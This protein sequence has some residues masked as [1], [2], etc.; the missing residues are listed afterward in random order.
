MLYIDNNGTAVG[1]AARVILHELVHALTTPILEDN[2]NETDYRGDTVTRSNEIYR[3]LGI[4][5]QNSYI[6]QSDTGQG[7][8]ADKI[9]TLG[10]NYTNGAAID[11]SVVVDLGINVDSTSWDSTDAGN[12]NDLLIGGLWDNKLTAGDGNDFL[13]GNEGNDTLYGGKGDDYL[14]GGEGADRLEGGEGYDTYI[15]DKQDTIMDEDGKGCVILDGTKLGLATRKKGETEYRDGYGNVFLYTEPSDGNPGH[16]SVNGGLQIENYTNGDLEIVL[17]E[18]P[19]DPMEPIRDKTRV[20]SKYASPIIL[21]LDGDGVETR[22]LANGTHFDHA[23]DGFAELTGWVGQDDGLLVRDL[24]G[25]GLIDSGRELFGSETLLANG[26]K[27]ANGFE[28]LKELDSNGD[29]IIDANDTAFA[30]LR[31]W[32]DSNGNGR[33]DEGE[34]LTLEQ[35]GVQSINLAYTNSNTVDAQGN[36]HKQTG[37][38]T[39]T[40]GQIRKA[41]DVWFAVDPMYSIATEQV[42]VPDDIAALPTARGYG[43]VRDLRQAMAM[44]ATGQLKV[45][46]TAFTQA[47]SAQDRMALVRQIIYRWTGVQDINPASR[48]NP[49][50]GNA[51]GD[52]RKLEALEKFLGEAWLQIGWGANPGRDA[53][54][55]LDEAYNLLEALVYSQLMMQ[56][57]LKGLFEQIVYSWDAETQSAQ[58]DLSQV[59]HTLASQIEA[60]RE[61]GLE[62]LGDFLLSLRGMGRLD[63]VDLDAFKAALLPLGADVAQTFDSA[64]TGWLSSNTPSDGNNRLIGTELDDIIDGKGG[65][66]LIFGRGGNDTLIG[67]M[68]NDV[69][70]G[71]AGNDSLNGGYGS[72]TYRFG[73]GDGHD[74]ISEYGSQSE[75]DR[76]ELKAGVTP[77]DVRLE[78]GSGNDLKLTIRDTGETITVKNHFTSTAY[79][80]EEIIFADGTVWDVEAIKSRV[81]LGEDG[82]DQLRGFDKRDDLI[83]GGAGN[84]VLMGYSGNDMLLGGEGNDTLDGGDGDDTLDGGAGDDVLKGGTGSDTYLFGRGD[85]HDTINEYS[86]VPG[87]TDRIQLK[88]GITP[89]DVRLERVRILSNGWLLSDDL[90]LTIRDTGETITVKNHFNNSYG[91]P[92]YAIE[93][94]VFAN[95]TV[96]DTEAIKSQTLIGGD[97]DDT[98][99]GF[100]NRDDLLIG[101]AGNDVLVGGSGN[102]TLVGGAGNDTLE[103][104]AGSDTYRFGLGDGQDEI[105]EGGTDG[106]DVLE[107]GPGITPDDVTVR[108]TLNGGM[109]ITLQDGSR[110]IV[111][112]QTW[113]SGWGIEQLRFANGTVWNR[114]DLAERAIA[115]TDGDDTIVGGYGNNTLDGGPGNDVFYDLG[116]YDT[117]LFG[118]GDGQD[119]I[120]DRDGRIQFKTGIDQNDIDFTYD[121]TDL[122]ATIAA[123]GDAI[124]IKDWLGSWWRI[125]RFDFANGASLS[126]ND[127]LAKLNVGEGSEILYGSPG[128]DTLIGTEKNSTIYGREGSDLLDGGAGSDVLYGEAGNDTLIGGAGNDTLYGG[129]GDDVLMG[130]DGDDWLFGGAGDD[131]LDGGAGRDWLYG[132]EGKNIYRMTPGMDLDMA[133]GESIQVAEDTVV[134]AAGIGP[135]DI[136]VQLGDLSWSEAPGDVGYR[137]L[138]IG[139]GGNDALVIQNANSWQNPDL[140]QGAIQHFRFAD[141]TEWTLADLIARADGGKL[142]YQWRESGDPTTLIGSAG[143]DTIR[144]DTGESVIVRAG[145]NN[146][147]IYLAAGNN[148]VSAG[149]GDDSINTGPGND[150]I[151]GETGDDWIDAG[152]GDDVILFNYGDGNDTLTA[153]KGMDTLSFGVTITSDMLSLAFNEYGVVVLTID[154]GAGGSITLSDAT[155]D[156]LRGDLERLQF[157]DADGK[158]RLFDFTGWLEANR[159]TLLGSTAPLAFD[160]AG[161][162]LTG[163]VA[164]VGGLEAVAYAQT[165]DLFGTAHLAN[166]TPTDGDDVIYGTPEGDLIDAGAGND[167][168]LGLAG[169]DT[170][171]GGEG[172]DILDGGDGDDILDGGA[173]NDTIYGGYGADTLIGGTG[174]DELYGGWGGDT[175]VY[176]PGDG[177]TIIDD[178]HHVLNWGRSVV[179]TMMAAFEYGGEI[180]YGGMI[181]DDDPNILSFGPGIRP[182][183]LRYSEHNGDLVITFANQPGD[184]VILRGYEPGRATQTRSVDIIRFADGTE[185]VAGSIDIRGKSEIANY[186]NAWLY[187]TQFADTLIGGD[188]DDTFYGNGGADRLAGGAGS[189]TYVIYK[190]WDSPVAETQIAEIWRPQDTNRIELTG[191]VNADDLRLAFDGRDLL[192]RYTPEGDTVRFLGFDPRDPNMPAPVQEISLP[193]EGITLSFDDLLARGVDYGDNPGTG[194]PQGPRIINRGDGEILI[195]EVA[196]EFSDILR[197]GPGIDAEAIRKNLRFESDGK[198]GHVLRIAYGDEGDVLCLAGFDPDDAL[199]S[200]LIEYYE[201]ADGP[202]LDYEA[203]L[204]EGFVVEGDGQDNELTGTN[205]ADRLYGHD[206][207]DVL[208]GKGGYNEFYGGKGNDTLIGGDQVDGYFF[209]RGD[210]ID[211][212]IDGPSD[213]FI[214]FGP[215]IG[216]SDLTVSWEDDT[217]VLRYGPGDE[218]RI[219]DFIAKT[220]DGTPPVT[221]I[222]FDDGD[223]VSIPS[224]I[225][226]S[227]TVQ[228]NAGEL[229]AATQDAMYWYTI[230]LADFDQSGPFGKARLLNLRQ[231]DGSALPGWL[232]FDAERGMLLGTPTNDDVGQL[233]LRVEIWGDYGLLATQQVSLLVNNVNDAPEIGTLLVDQQAKQDTSFTYTLPAGSFYDVDVGDVLTYTATLDNGDPLPDWL[234][235]DA[236]TQTFTGTPANGDVGKLQLRVT[237]TDL[238]G[239]SASQS[240]TLDVMSDGDP[241]LPITAPDTASVLEDSVVIGN[242][243]AN[244]TNPGTVASFRIDG[245]P[246]VYTAG[247]TATIAEG[248]LTI[249]SHGDYTFMPAQDYSGLVPQ[250]TYTTSS[251]LSSTLDITVIPVADAPVVTVTLGELETPTGNITTIDWTNA[252]TTSNGF[253]MQAFTNLR[254]DLDQS[255]AAEG[256]FVFDRS[257]LVSSGVGVESGTIKGFGSSDNSSL[258]QN[259]SGPGANEISQSGTKV[260]PEDWRSE[261]VRVTF[262]QSVVS[263]TVQFAWLAILEHAQY[264]A[265][266]ENGDVVVSGIVNGESDASTALREINIAGNS[267]IKSI[268]FFAPGPYAGGANT[269][270]FLIY[271]IQ[272][273]SPST[274]PS[275]LPVAISVVPTD[276]DGSE[277]VTQITVA[278]TGGVLSAGTDNHDGTWT[279]RADDPSPDYIWSV[280]THGAV[281]IKDLN[282]NDLGITVA[283]NHAGSVMVDV[284]ATV[285]DSLT[286]GTD[287]WTDST[288]GSGSAMLMIGQ[289]FSL[290]S[291]GDDGLGANTQT[292]S[293][294]LPANLTSTTQVAATVSD[295]QSESISDIFTIS[296]NNGSNAA[297]QQGNEGIGAPPRHTPNQNDRP[298]T[299]LGQPGNQSKNGKAERSVDESLESFLHGFGADSPSLSYVSR[300]SLDSGELAHWGEGQPASAETSD[301]ARRWAALSEVLNRLDAERQAAPGWSDVHWGAGPTGLAGLLQGGQMAGAGVDAISLAS[302]GS[303][304][305]SLAGLHEGMEKI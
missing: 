31:V 305:K 3:D 226:D 162:E 97:G 169:N 248:T 14:N 268:E 84:D 254:L 163:T 20:A 239:A 17:V 51:I 128:D 190:E 117:Y 299:V 123:S 240:F 256:K 96:W 287:T 4:P 200:H 115:G 288:T 1:G 179:P 80:I 134:F 38:Y 71:G 13:Y 64:L 133:Y 99:L 247:Q 60:D 197:F 230:P 201:F 92:Y 273:A 172:N 22:S 106:E 10:F 11:R 98:L 100:D 272:F 8:K 103:G 210:G 165:G 130:G 221:A 105:I 193:W 52:A 205:L 170:I 39:T 94:I 275:T 127:V 231:A 209:E 144:D 7:P 88:A 263:A 16:L 175:Y 19:D 149:S 213:N 49:S 194:E 35:A 251:G 40:D 156:N 298:D 50:W 33:V 148:I 86:W 23:A 217:L 274:E 189:D 233:E 253:T 58:G 199:G 147:A 138:V 137:D 124:R 212:I 79:G 281:T 259:S 63:D 125:D 223:M 178:D 297:K 89:D 181:V 75:T 188:G 27:A 164:P 225:S 277:S 244:D 136:T 302:S 142:G 2:W 216:K 95:G 215:G 37:S 219:P 112:N 289:S 132:G 290:G 5:E 184:R 44:D 243:L 206:G 202:V 294:T 47:D 76:L 85:G 236:V 143:D 177:Q 185:I 261:L 252:K 65:N 282:G 166:N 183:D 155:A 48:T 70:D 167:I 186:E 284:S 122:I 292:F 264:V 159:L 90:K 161:F 41:E 158:A 295:G 171:F 57:H 296:L 304:F 146:D 250:V 153:G 69:L 53:A 66:D 196:G 203:L 214:V 18:E 204:S 9:L 271:S 224:L 81:L 232:M 291:T 82:D 74:M 262:D 227:E 15:A 266:A 131:D 245:D 237:A 30:E 174:N 108:W 24:N 195:N 242:V 269:D 59:A 228:W 25:N 246:A 54:R 129:D 28:A 62:V 255:N 45:L 160:G 73:R 111:R 29:G 26:K 91:T 135:E 241:Q 32:K 286:I 126:F 55:T 121:G 107:L 258:Y 141:G 140:G 109:S 157:I 260:T 187:G 270:D 229:P 234:T 285:I 72:D 211:T 61:M 280:D 276:I 113:S 283:P 139:I 56:S 198:G 78:R 257:R 300:A 101:G 191:D 87:E 102:D 6:S 104:G 46:V 114:D 152:E 21:D 238:A 119:T 34:L 180:G 173:G 278:V 77:D 151:A 222:R 218:I 208:T 154:G 42:E 267:T 303:Q 83:V 176:Q 182:E 12:S 265:Y 116:G 168:V 36:T 293:D 110:V 93:E 118:I 150:I 249:D 301:I 220:S 235:F 207:D 68:G 67:G 43:K 120:T 145:A 192:L 279:F